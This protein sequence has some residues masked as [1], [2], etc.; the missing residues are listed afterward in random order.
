VFAEPANRATAATAILDVVVGLG[1]KIGVE[2]IA[3]GLESEAD[4]ATAAGSGCGYGQGHLIGRP[5]PPEHLEAY[6]DGHRS[7]A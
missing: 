2:V 6:L 3:Q 4:M 1:H 7:P 5:V